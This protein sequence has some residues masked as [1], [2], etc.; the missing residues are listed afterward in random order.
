M[1]IF[2]LNIWG[3]RL[4]LPRFLLLCFAFILIALPAQAQSVI[5]D[6]EI[7]RYLREMSEPIFVQAGLNP[8]DV[9]L[10]IV[11]DPSLNAFVMGGQN[12]F[13]H[14]GLILETEEVGEL[15]GVIAHET[16]HIAAGHLVRS[17]EVGREAGIQSIITTLVGA[18]AGLAGGGGEAAGAIIAGGQANAIDYQLRNSRTYESSADQAAI[19][20]MDDAG[21]SGRGMAGFL[22]KL[23]SQELLP[24]SQQVEYLRTHPLTR[25]RVNAMIAAVEQTRNKETPWP[26]AF[27]KYHGRMQAKILGFMAPNQVAM[28]YEGRSDFDADYARAIA[29]YRQGDVDTALRE[30]E[31]LITQEPNNGHLYELKGQILFEN[32]RIDEALTAYRQAIEMVPEAGLMRLEFAKA[33]LER[34]DNSLLEEAIKNLTLA[35]KSEPT[36]PRLHRLFATAYGLMGQDGLAKVHLAEEAFLKRDI[37]FA[38]QQARLAKEALPEDSGAWQRA[39]DLL[40]EIENQEK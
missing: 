30:I 20:Y 15:V 25:D 9:R 18:A 26:V 38:I 3:G 7:E 13:L 35:L 36:T 8:N 12:I 34:R 24:A 31:T 6:S 22:K 37:P 29:R 10:I 1:K 32:S 11:N 5:R 33:L 19:A 2:Q 27:Q 28:E 16:G 14:T 21:Y 4:T 23:A 40:T 39:S 17:R